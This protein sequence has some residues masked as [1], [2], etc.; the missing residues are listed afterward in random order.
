VVDTG[1]IPADTTYAGGLEI[2][3]VNG[4]LCVQG[5]YLH[6][7]VQAEAGPVVNFVGFYASASWFLTGESRPYDRTQG[8]FGRLVPKQNFNFGKGGWGAWEFAGRYSF[9]DLSDEG[10]QGGRLT[11]LMA[12]VNW[13]L[14]SHVKWRF[15]YGFGRVSGRQP[16]GNLNIFQTRVEV[17]F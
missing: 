7:W 10:I 11:M 1:D 3:W 15:N 6:S 9:V 16:E 17:D 4:P 14:H 12:G 5:E 8:T 2:A 13:Y